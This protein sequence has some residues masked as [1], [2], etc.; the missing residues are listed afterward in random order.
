MRKFCYVLM[1]MTIIDLNLFCD[2]LLKWLLFLAGE[3]ERSHLLRFHTK[4]ISIKYYSILLLYIVHRHS[5]IKKSVSYCMNEDRR[6]FWS[7]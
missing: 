4:F 7:H 3:E 2:S 6:T 5:K 1:R